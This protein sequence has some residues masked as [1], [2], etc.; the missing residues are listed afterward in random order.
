MKRLLPLI[1]IFTS[2]LVS[3]S[4][5]ERVNAPMED[6][7][8]VI[9][10]TIDS[11]NKVK[12]ARPVAGS[13]RRGDNPVL[14]L[15]GNSTM[16]T[17][18]L[19]NGNNGQW[20]WGYFFPDYF[21]N[22]K[23]SVENQALGGM[24][25]RTFYNRLWPDVLKGIKEGDWVIIELGH[26]DNGPYDSGRA[27]ASIPGIGRD[28]LNIVIQETGNKEPVYSFGEYMRRYIDD[29]R[30][31][32]AT[33]ILLSLTPRNAWID[34]DSTKIER[35]Y[36]T[37]G[38]WAKAIAH[39]KQCTFID[40][41]RISAD[42]FEKFGKDKVKTMFYLDNIHSS[43][44]GAKLNAESA[45]EGL[46]MSDSELKNYLK[47]LPEDSVTAASRIG[48]E[49]LTF[50]IGDKPCP[51][52]KELT[53]DIDRINL[54]LKTSFSHKSECYCD[55]K[56][57]IRTFVENGAWDKIYRKLQ[58]GDLVLIDFT[59]NPER[60]VDSGD[61]SGTLPGNGAESKVVKLKS[62]GQYK[63]VYTFGWYLRKIIMDTKE[64]G[65]IPMRYS[66]IYQ[67]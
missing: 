32:G 56:S 2:T 35:V 64:K 24:S 51:D 42:K 65:A 7:N 3:F 33:P 54:E 23:I 12:T 30:A 5:T 55:P 63:V 36:S 48:D 26:N 10:N 15:V 8:N 52:K 53:N 59:E 27:R 50:I 46:L 61:E 34:S 9:D 44:Y 20:G 58:P 19:G 62:N 66:S 39:E 4:Q 29:V 57:S 14:F 6:R 31:K 67:D 1:A 60:P 43:E 45:R 49:T 13:T 16:R 40:L 11:L 47:V 37:F 28:S 25:S 18:T 21:D 38:A 22:E 41:N 17:G